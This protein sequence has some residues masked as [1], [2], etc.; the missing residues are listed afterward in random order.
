MHGAGQGLFEWERRWFAAALPPAPARILLGGAG[1]R[2]EADWLWQQAFELVAFDPVPAF[3]AKTP[4]QLVGAYE[5]LVRPSNLSEVHFRDAVLA[6]APYDAAV[7]GWGSFTHLVCADDRAS[8]L[9]FLR[10]HVSGN[11]LLSVWLCTGHLQQALTKR[12]GSLVGRALRRRST[13]ALERDQI[14]PHCGFS[15]AFERE[16]LQDLAT[17]ARYRLQWEGDQHDFPHAT[18]TPM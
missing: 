7:L 10:Q 12:L 5:G 17:E 8:V 4:D 14:L 6:R 15:H 3:A 18:L 16:E 2:R 13:R 1:R 9:R 11:V